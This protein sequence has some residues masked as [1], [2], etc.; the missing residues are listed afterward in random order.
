ME[1]PDKQ[2]EINVD[3]TPAQKDALGK[4]NFIPFEFVQAL[5]KLKV[6]FYSTRVLCVFYQEEVAPETQLYKTKF[7]QFKIWGY[8]D[9]GGVP[10]EQ[11]GYIKPIS[12]QSMHAIAKEFGFD[13][14]EPSKVSL[15]LQKKNE[16]LAS[17]QCTVGQ[18][19]KKLEM[20]ESLFKKTLDASRQNSDAPSDVDFFEKKGTKKQKKN[21]GSAVAVGGGKIIDKKKLEAAMNDGKVKKNKKSLEKEKAAFLSA[22]K[23]NPQINEV[24][25]L[26]DDDDE[27]DEK[28]KSGS[29]ENEQ[30]HH[31]QEDQ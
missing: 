21:D 25:N 4:L 15:E 18:L 14:P 16:Q 28:E 11:Q 29:E 20:F 5:N 26:G 19:T 1:K 30:E 22:S 7:L 23:V 3:L 6:I 2:K 17:L 9:K 31:F 10:H 8:K 24:I 13:L 27:K 12:K